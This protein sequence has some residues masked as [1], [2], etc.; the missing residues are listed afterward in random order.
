MWRQRYCDLSY[1]MVVYS[2]ND[3]I[4]IYIHNMVGQTIASVYNLDLGA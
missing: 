2:N 1:E 3:H 4:Y